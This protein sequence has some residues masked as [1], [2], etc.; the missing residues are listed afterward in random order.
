MISPIE[1]ADPVNS[2]EALR[3]IINKINE[4]IVV[5]NAL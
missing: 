5:V 2:E 4:I 1:F 3:T